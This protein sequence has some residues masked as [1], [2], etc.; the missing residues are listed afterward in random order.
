MKE[1]IAQIS[2]QSY[3][4]WCR[5]FFEADVTAQMK[6]LRILLG[7]LLFVAYAIRAI[8]NEYY[9]GASGVLDLEK[10]L[11]WFPMQYRYS[12]LISFPGALALKICTGVFLVSLVTLGFGI[13]SRFSALIAFVMHVSFMHRNMAI[14]YGLDMIS[15][16]FLFYLIFAKTD[17]KPKSKNSWAQML[18]SMALRFTQIQVC[19]IYAYS[20]WEKLKGPAWWRGEAIWSVFANTQIARWNM[21]WVAHFPLVISAVT[22]ATLLFE[23]YFPALI[24]LKRWRAALLVL[25]VLL[26]LG[27]GLVVFI[28]FFS[29]LMVLSYVSFLTPNEAEWILRRV[30]PLKFRGRKRIAK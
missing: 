4:A 2:R 17:S 12:F 15:A 19:V 6:L 8:D 21:D 27:I 20:G 9:Y 29:A 23:I 26:H 28:P 3:Q 24:W 11:E 5:F 30:N 10:M 16:F 1:R 14:V 13:F 22:Y 7:G 25:G 18:S